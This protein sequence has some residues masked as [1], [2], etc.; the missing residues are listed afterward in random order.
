MASR[1][2]DHS[3]ELFP[4]GDDEPNAATAAPGKS[5]GP[6]P[7]AERMRPRT[8]D[9]LVGQEET[10]GPGKPLRRSIEEDRLP[11]LILWGRPGRARPPSP[12]SCAGGRPHTSRR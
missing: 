5:R 2:D 10:L 6:A 1:R 11:S 3:G 8:L 9:E 4:T 12:T 7:L